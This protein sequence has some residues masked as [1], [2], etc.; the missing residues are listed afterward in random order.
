[1]SGKILIVDG[2]ATNR[3]LLKV[4]LGTACHPVVQAASGAEALGLAAAAAPALVLADLALPDMDGIDLCRRLRAAPG[5]EGLPIILLGA[6]IDRAQRLAALR[7]GADEVLGKP[8]DEALLL[9]RIRSLLRARQ[10]DQDLRLRAE[11]CRDFGLAEAPAPFD[12]PPQ[13]A[14]VAP[15]A[16]GALG[17]RAALAPHLAATWRP[18]TP[19]AALAGA[20]APGAPDLYVVAADLDR[21]GAGLRLIADLRSRA[22]G[23]EAGLC[24][25]LPRPWDGAAALALDLGADALVS[26]PL[27][28][29]ETALRL[30]GLQARR[31]RAEALR[32]AVSAGLHLAA[33][34]ALTGLWNRR[35]ARAH[36][37]RV[38]AR[39][40]A[41]GLRCAVMVLDLDRFKAVNDHWGHAAGDAVLVEV[42]AR[43]GR[44]LG[45]SGL[46]AR[47]GGEEF[48]VVLDDTGP[49]AARVVAE[50]LCRA[51]AA[52]PF[53]LPGG[54]GAVVVTLSAGLALSPSGG[55]DAGG[56]PVGGQAPPGDAGHARACGPDGEDGGPGAGLPAHRLAQ[57]L[58]CQADAALFAAKG[59]GRNQVTT[60]TAA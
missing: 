6:G 15:D 22:G 10:S 32:R 49:D 38:A 25:A 28:G 59:E 37:D 17:W 41:Q 19:A 50:R 23:S 11:T 30:A 44:A 21:P 18:L 26:L 54:A 2:T 1:M 53:E 52:Q 12:R 55:V 47:I 36:L 34:D 33:T 31:R 51:V 7:A 27:D 58:L 16:A 42:A 24:L 20:H 46:L 8:L 4:K 56:G 39:A 9:A 57:A 5:A 60:A 45:P 40:L 35:Y 43:L 3:I 29:A 13:V 14:L 48:L